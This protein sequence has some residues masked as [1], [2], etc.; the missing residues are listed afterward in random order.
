E[1]IIFDLNTFA[2]ATGIPDHDGNAIC[3][4]KS[5]NIIKCIFPYALFCIFA[6]FVQLSLPVP[7]HRRRLWQELRRGF[8]IVYSAS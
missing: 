2:V 7:F 6:T 1:E 4:L 3:L 5:I 8:C